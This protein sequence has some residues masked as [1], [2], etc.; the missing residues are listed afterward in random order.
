MSF[1]CGQTL[2]PPSPVMPLYLQQHPFSCLLTIPSSLFQTFP[3]PAQP[4][5]SASCRKP[6]LLYQPLQT[7]CLYLLLSLYQFQ[8]GWGA[9]VGGSQRR[10]VAGE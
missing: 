8:A 9:G 1:S 10:E 7:S 4:N 3:A 5:P 2:P 6:S